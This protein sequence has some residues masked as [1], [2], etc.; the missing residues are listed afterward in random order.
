MATY[1]YPARL[2]WMIEACGVYADGV[3][4]WTLPFDAEAAGIDTIVL[5]SAF[6]T[7]A[8]TVITGLTVE[9]NAVSVD[10][11]YGMGVVL[12]GRLIP[13]RLVITKPFPRDRSGRAIIGAITRTQR[14][15]VRHHLTGSYT[16]QLERTGYPVVTKTFSADS[17]GIE[18]DG[19][20]VIRNSGRSEGMKI[21][22]TSNDPRPITIAAI[23]FHFISNLYG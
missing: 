23:R 7:S 18:E 17:N 1:P 10:G 19:E 21:T 12:I 16:V 6:A 15:W 8:G 2:D 4:T 11:N 13:F 22:I 14:F 9:G 5:S 20:L 3:T